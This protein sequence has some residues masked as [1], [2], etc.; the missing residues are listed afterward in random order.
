MS[1]VLNEEGLS[2]ALGHVPFPC[3][4]QEFRDHNAQ[5]LKVYVVG[6][7]VFWSDKKSLPDLSNFTTTTNSAAAA[8]QF[9][10]L[11]NMPTSAADLAQRLGVTV[12]G[13]AGAPVL[14]SSVLSR[15]TIVATA[16]AIRT[17]SGLSIFGFDIIVPKGDVKQFLVVDLNA[18]PS[19]KGFD[20]QRAAT[21]IASL[22]A[23]A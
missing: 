4:L 18:F 5:Q 13:E 21:A 2:S 9:N 22:F 12:G 1:L 11:E 7:E 3:V 20:P 10:T 15:E 8:V 17:S 16:D 23:A 6:S 19:F 14:V